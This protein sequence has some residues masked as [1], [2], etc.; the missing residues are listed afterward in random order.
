MSPAATA[1]AQ[2]AGI[3]KLEACTKVLRQAAARVKKVSAMV[4]AYGAESLRG[5][6]ITSAICYLSLIRLVVLAL[7]FSY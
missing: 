6:K 3:C 4:R 7:E 5:P 2:S 1:A